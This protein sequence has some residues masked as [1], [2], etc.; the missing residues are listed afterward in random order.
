MPPA[1]LPPELEAFLERPRPAVIATVRADGS[2]VTAAT[3]YEWT[4]GRFLVTMDAAGRRIRNIRGNPN[5]ALTV[6][7]DS[8]Y[9]HVSLLGRAVEIR[10]D[11]DFVDVDR[12]SM[13]YSG[14]PYEPR[15]WSSV[16]V[17]V[18]VER[19]H[20]WGDPGSAEA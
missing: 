20:T 11:P 10:D 1:P 13:R 7:G 14:K 2:P 12:L 8:W 4:G 3:W 17:V 16:A 9:D 15:D 18:E 19:W 6:L 5:V